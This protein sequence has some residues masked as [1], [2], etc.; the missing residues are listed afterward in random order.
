MSERETRDTSHEHPE[1]KELIKSYFYNSFRL[2]QGRPEVQFHIF[3]WL[4]Y[5]GYLEDITIPQKSACIHK[6]EAYTY[7]A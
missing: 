1:D 3:Q 2:Y 4:A 7:T 6:T 5:H